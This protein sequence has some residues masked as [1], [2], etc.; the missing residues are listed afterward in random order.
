MKSYS[1]LAVPSSAQSSPRPSFPRHLPGFPPFPYRGA[2]AIVPGT[3]FV[4]W[5]RLQSLQQASAGMGK[6][7][8]LP[9]CLEA[10]KEVTVEHTRCGGQCTGHS[11][12]E[13]DLLLIV[14]SPGLVHMQT[15]E[16]ISGLGHFFPNL[17]RGQ[18]LCGAPYYQ[19]KK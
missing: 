19:G 5:V 13:R 9:N 8:E 7:A 2:W 3:D 10:G 18:L 15:R 6:G 1:S 12:H 4:A 17:R 14:S 11:A 16:R